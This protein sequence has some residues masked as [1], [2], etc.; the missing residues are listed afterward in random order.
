VSINQRNVH[1][2]AS[3]VLVVPFSAS[4]IKE[5]PTHVYLSP[6]ESGMEASV[7]KAEDVAVVLKTSLIE[8]RTKLRSLTH[9]R[10]CEL[11]SKIRIAMGCD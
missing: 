10:I 7:L 4:T 1:P 8:P 2:R 9:S 11:A 3:T 6:G 5:V